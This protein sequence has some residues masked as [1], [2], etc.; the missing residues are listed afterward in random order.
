VTFTYLLRYVDDPGA[1]LAEIARV[2]KPGGRVVSRGGG[3]SRS[4]A[5]S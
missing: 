5:R 4:A 2:V 3:R 1:T